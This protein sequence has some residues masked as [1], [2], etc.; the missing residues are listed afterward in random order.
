MGAWFFGLCLPFL[1]PAAC[2]WEAK[3][4]LLLHLAL[5]YRWGS[6][7]LATQGWSSVKGKRDNSHSKRRLQHRRTD[8]ECRV[9]DLGL[10]LS[11]NNETNWMQINILN[12]RHVLQWS[13]RSFTQNICHI[14]TQYFDRG[15]FCYEKKT[16]N[17][18]STQRLMQTKPDFATN[19]FWRD[20]GK[21][22]P[23]S[24]ALRTLSRSTSITVTIN[25]E[26]HTYSFVFILQRASR[27]IRHADWS[28]VRSASSKMAHA[29]CQGK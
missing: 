8:H 16:R 4:L 25:A 24:D 10:E 22:R 23:W 19:L 15:N 11:Q 20:S 2:L 5:A 6:G 3:P 29:V 14:H 12:L 1:C 17:R 13:M 7:Q 27:R 28:V 9:F 18:K 21:T 26:L